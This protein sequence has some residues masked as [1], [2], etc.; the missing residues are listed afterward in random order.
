VAIIA[1]KIAGLDKDDEVAKVRRLYSRRLL[2]EP[3]DVF[4]RETAYEP[5]RGTLHRYR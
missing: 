4:H 1:V 3:G 2:L 5:W